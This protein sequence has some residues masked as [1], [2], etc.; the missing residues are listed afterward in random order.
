MSVTGNSSYWTG[1]SEMQNVYEPLL[2]A[3]L[4]GIRLRAPYHEKL[5][6]PRSWSYACDDLVGHYRCVEAD[7][8][9]ELSNRL[10]SVISLTLRRHGGKIKN[11]RFLDKSQV[12]SV[13][14]VFIDKLLQ[15]TPAR[16]SCM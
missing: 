13:K 8:S 1:A 3:Q 11:P 4:S 14:M 16:I 15:G 7:A 6:P 5:S 10:R 2:P 12:F 9:E